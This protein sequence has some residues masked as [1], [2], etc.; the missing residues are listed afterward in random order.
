MSKQLYTDLADSS[1]F[2]NWLPLPTLQLRCKEDL[3]SVVCQYKTLV[4]FQGR[5]WPG[6]S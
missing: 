1:I 4:D 5:S 3:V 6:E 2:W